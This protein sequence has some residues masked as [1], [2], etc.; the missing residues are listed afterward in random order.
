[1]DQA[2]KLRGSLQT[3]MVCV[4]WTKTFVLRGSTGRCMPYLWADGLLF[5]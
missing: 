4:Y 3:E 2:R 5:V 1:M